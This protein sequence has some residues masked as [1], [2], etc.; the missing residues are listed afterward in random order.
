MPQSVR[1]L[2]NSVQRYTLTLTIIRI[3]QKWISFITIRF[4]SDNK[5]NNFRFALELSIL[6]WVV[7]ASPSRKNNANTKRRN[8]FFNALWTQTRDCCSFIFFVVAKTRFEFKWGVFFRFGSA[9]FCF[10][11]SIHLHTNISTSVYDSLWKHLCYESQKDI[12]N[13]IRKQ[14]SWMS[15]KSCIA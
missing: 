14:H 3:C 5:K 15:T 1:Y 11:H 10:S 9:M 4:P 6:H 2:I 12:L 13:S 8:T 7:S